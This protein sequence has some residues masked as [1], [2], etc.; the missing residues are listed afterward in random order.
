LNKVQVAIQRSSDALYW[1]GSTWVSGI[2]WKD[3]NGTTSWN[4]FFSESYLTSGVSYMVQSRAIDNLG[5]IQTTPDSKSFTYDTTAPTA[6]SITR[7]D[8]NPTKATALSWTVTFA[9]PVNNVASANFAL[10]T[11]GLGGTAPSITS[12]TPPSGPSTTWTVTASMS[13]TT[14][15]AGSIQLNLTSS[16]T[17][18]DRAT[19][20]LSATVPVAGQAY[21]FDTTAPTAADFQAA[22]GTGTGGRIGSGD[23]LTFTYSEAMDP[24]SIKSGW[25]GTATSVTVTITDAGS[26]DTLTVSFLDGTVSLGGNYIQST[27]VVTAT[28]VMS[29]STITVT[30]T[31]SPPSGQLNTVAS[32]TMEWSPD[33][34]AKDIAGNAMSSGSAT[35]SGSP[36]DQDF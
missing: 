30:L 18:Q 19:N 24:N 2:V 15:S 25:D 7:A 8:A 31:A 6:P 17:I 26:A 11:S 33:L 29:G 23:A 10:V 13:G 20:A 16:G 32:G 22:N 14:A 28:M 1:N 34:T 5:N 35:E 3:V 21:T 4:F 12:V 36:A 27:R 9:E